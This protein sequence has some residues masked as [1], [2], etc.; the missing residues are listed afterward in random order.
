MLRFAQYALALYA[1]H[2]R[3]VRT[4]VVYLGRHIGEEPEQQSYGAVSIRV[5][6]IYLG[7]REAEAV[8]ARLGHASPGVWTPK[9]DLDLAFLPFM[10]HATLT[11]R[12]L[13]NVSVDLLNKAPRNHQM[14]TA[15]VILALTS[16]FLNEDLV[17]LLLGV[18]QM[19]DLIKELEDEA[20]ERGLAQGLARGLEL[21]RQQGMRQGKIDML[22]AILRARFHTVPDELALAIQR[23]PDDLFLTELAPYALNAATIDDVVAWVQKLRA[24]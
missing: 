23:V 13:V 4:L 17:K 1:Q 20:I 22:L 19:R 18:I 5:H 11:Q 10:A 14:L 2:R 21:G 6:N 12:D 9:D 16:R 24:Q 8:I 15:A 7:R 3:P